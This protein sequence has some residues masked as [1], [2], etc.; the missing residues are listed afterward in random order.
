LSEVPSRDLSADW[1]PTC[2]H[3]DQR[4]AQRRTQGSL[5]LFMDAK[6]LDRQ[7]IRI[8]LRQ[9]SI[10]C[11]RNILIASDRL[12]AQSQCVPSDMEQIVRARVSITSL[13]S[14]IVFLTRFG[15]GDKPC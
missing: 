4:V 5:A 11:L 15:K 14:E 6:A 7:S 2:R 1:Q 3:P 9:N 12:C 13:M 10:L 8:L